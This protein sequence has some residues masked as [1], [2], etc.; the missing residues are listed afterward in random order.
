MPHPAYVFLHYS[1]PTLYQRI[2]TERRPDGYHHLETVFYPVGLCDVLDVVP[3]DTC[4]DYSFSTDGIVVDGD[5][6]DNLIIKAYR[7]L[8]SEY[9][10][11]PVDITF[12]KQIPFGAGLGG[13][14]SDAAFMLKVLN[15]LA[16][17]KLSA[18]KMEE[19]AVRLGAD[20]PVFIKNRPVY[21]TGIGNVFKP[22][23]LSLKGYYLLL[24][25]P[26]VHVHILF[27]AKILKFDVT[28]IKK[29]KT[30]RLHFSKFTGF[31]IFFSN[32]LEDSS[33]KLYFC[34]R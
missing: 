6:E 4:S 23:K 17:L 19:L 3:S 32:I 16:A 11:P 31:N 5:V 7:L 2:I 21:A 26:E 34:T 27:C 12:I 25:K 29:E 1:H 30:R 10:V 9:P 28:Y 15:D 18:K 13:G 22:L 20:C 14:S 33:K 8:Q 24:V